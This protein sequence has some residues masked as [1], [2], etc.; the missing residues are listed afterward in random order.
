MGITVRT[1]PPDSTHCLDI[2]INH[3][4]AKKFIPPTITGPIKVNQ[5]YF[6]VPSGGV[7]VAGIL[8]A[9]FWTNH[10]MNPN[11]LLPSPLYP[12]ALSRASPSSNCPETTDRNSLGKSVMAE[13]RDDGLTFSQ[14]VAMPSGFVYSTAVNTDQQV[15]LPAAQRLGVFIFGVPRYR[16]SIPYL[17]Y[18][19]LI[20]F[21]DPT[22]W[23]FFSGL[24]V[25]GQPKWVTSAVWSAKLH[26]RQFLD[27]SRRSGTVQCVYGCRSL[28]RRIL[29]H[30]EFSSRK[31]AHA[32]QLRAKH[33][34][35]DRLCSLGT[36][37]STG[38]HI[39]C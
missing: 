30:L 28:C 12:L 35:P 5:G 37:V 23:H 9:F 10:C 29:D 11:S 27:S 18:A 31:M 20:S 4:A 26:A 1:A 6:N 17:A 13:S 14:V 2:V 39:E 15:G 25:N 33:S 8:Y 3:N 7:S 16:A 32:L 38:C 22:S 21:T 24:D 19:P 34:S 36:L